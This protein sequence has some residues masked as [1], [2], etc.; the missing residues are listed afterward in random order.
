MPP[1]DWLPAILVYPIPGDLMAVRRDLVTWRD[2]EQ[3][4]EGHRRGQT[5]A[6]HRGWRKAY[7]A[8][9][10]KLQMLDIMME[11]FAPVMQAHPT[12][13]FED[14]CARLP[15]QKLKVVKEL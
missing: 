4:H 5:R 6:Q 2:L 10:A 12:L 13:G 15:A 9:S 14:A 8:H 3:A 11:T 1:G 7:A